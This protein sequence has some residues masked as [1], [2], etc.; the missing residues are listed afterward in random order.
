MSEKEKIIEILV[1]FRSD[2]L[3]DEI[4]GVFEKLPDPKIK[5]ILFKQYEDSIKAAGEKLNIDSLELKE[6]IE[7]KAVDLLNGEG[8]SEEQINKRLKEYGVSLT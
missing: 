7:D 3:W 6:L 2:L 4:V 5:D 8:F 1:K